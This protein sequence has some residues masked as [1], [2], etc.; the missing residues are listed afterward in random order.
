MCV[1][2]DKF[3]QKN[4]YLDKFIQNANNKQKNHSISML[5]SNLINIYI[6]FYKINNNKYKIFIL[7]YGIILNQISKKIIN[8]CLS[9]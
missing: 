4:F 3:H 8:S 1:Y 6:C 2:T 5:E 7:L 9:L